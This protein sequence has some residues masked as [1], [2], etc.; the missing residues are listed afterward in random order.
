MQNYFGFYRAKVVDNEDPE[1]FG[2]VLV[3]IPDLMPDIAE[4]EGVWARS[5]NNPVGGRNQENPTG[6]TS[7]IPWKNSW[8]WI[9]FEGGNV[10]VP[11]YF[12]ALDIETEQSKTLPEVRSGESYDKWVIFKSIAGRAIVI[13]DDPDDARVEITGAKVTDSEIFKI[14]DNQTVILLNEGGGGSQILIKTRN[15]DYLNIDID[16]RT[17]HAKFGGDIIMESTENIKFKAGGDISL[18][19]G[20]NLNLKATGNVAS[21][22]GG[23]F[24]GKGGGTAAIDGSTVLIN[25]GAA[26]PANGSGGSANGDRK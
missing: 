24:S 13:S 3:W 23:N 15:G 7:Y 20:G 1:N 19:A 12:G 18:L 8:V 4:T 16:Q 11:Y 21:D 10:N 6:G 14:D 2:R 17:F 26:G 25:K 9:F 5:A 22:A